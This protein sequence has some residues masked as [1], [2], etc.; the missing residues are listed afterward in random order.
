MTLA[1][2]GGGA[3]G[4]YEAGAVHALAEAGLRFPLVCGA[5]I[6]AIN[7]AFYA[8]G[9]GSPE[10]TAHMADV[11]RELART[12]VV[13]MNTRNLVIWAAIMAFAAKSP[14]LALTAVMKASH[15]VPLLDPAPVEAVLDQYI[16][17][18]KVG[19]WA[20][21]LHIAA[22]AAATPIADVVA[23]P[24]RAMTYFRLRDMPP[25]EARAAVLASAAIPMAFPPRKVQ[26]TLYV[27]A[28]YVLG[29][30]AR[31]LYELGARRICSVFL[32]DTSIQNRDDLPGATL[33]QIRPSSNIDL[34]LRSTF[35]FSI[36]TVERLV[37]LGY[38]DAER[39]LRQGHEWMDGLMTLRHQGDA[40]EEATAQIPDR[41]PRTFRGPPDA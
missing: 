24:W 14:K 29:P 2:S 4:A 16:H 27:D 32:N 38:A 37:A 21:D 11:W 12:G 10:H 5:S 22:L 18:D 7:A 15:Y 26:G 39:A 13:Q 40:L 23:A 3:R 17:F 1:L 6:G 9:D 36:D 8:Q 28:A 34:G 30:P 31:H 20:V 25:A 35:D 41:A 19:Q 33:F